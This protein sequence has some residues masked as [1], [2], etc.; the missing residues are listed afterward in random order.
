MCIVSCLSA[1]PACVSR[2]LPGLPLPPRSTV[3]A[4]G[5]RLVVCSV[6]SGL[7]LRSRAV[8]GLAQRIPRKMETPQVGVRMGAMH[9]DRQI[10]KD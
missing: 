3:P 2:C 6:V 4:A 9:E 7:P 8:A 5:C 1:S 10:T